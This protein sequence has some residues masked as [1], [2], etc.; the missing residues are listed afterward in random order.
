MELSTHQQIFD[1]LNKAK[2]ILVV[3]PKNID[4]DT[5]GSALALR[6][7]LQKLEKNVEIVSS[8][9]IPKEC[10]FL[11]G[12]GEIKTAMSSSQSFVVIV[13]AEP[14]GLD[15][16]SYETLDGKVHIFLKAKQGAFTQEDVSFDSEKPA[17]DTI[18]ILGSASLEHVGSLFEQHADVFFNTPKINIDNKPEN[19]YFGAINLVDINA[20]SI[21]EILS[22]LFAAYETQLID[23]DIATCLLTGIITK[24]NSFQHVH[25]TPQVFLKASEL[26]SLGGRQQEV[27]KYVYKT[28]SFALLKLWGRALARLKTEEDRQMVYSLLNLGDFERSEAGPKKSRMF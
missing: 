25:T 3:L 6:L 11:P 22:N 14:K 9:P 15:E 18:V 19:E 8:A 5:T 2:N 27:V 4:A 12:A 13:N 20:T 21:A 16:L 24:T 26:V 7:F 1:Q 17:V 28:K 10:Q 23:E